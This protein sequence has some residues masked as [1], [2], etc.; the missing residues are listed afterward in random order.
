MKKFIT[1]L[2]A[3]CITLPVWAAD[4]AAGIANPATPAVK[5]QLDQT[6]KAN[7]VSGPT[8][9]AGA[10]L[11]DIDATILALKEQ[12][13]PVP[14]D[15]YKA[16]RELRGLPVHEV[17]AG[18][19]GGDTVGEATN[20]SSLPFSDTGTTIGYT[21]DYDEVCPYTDSTSPDVVYSFTPGADITVYITLCNG[22]DY[23]TKL[24]VYENEVTPGAPFACNDD[25]CVNYESELYG[26]EL[27]YGNTYFIVIDGYFGD[28]GNY[29]LDI[30][31][32]G[33]CDVECPPE[34][35]DEGEEE[36]YDEYV[37]AT[38]GG[39]NSDPN[40]FGAVGI[41][42]YVCGKGGTFMFEGGNFRD[43][44]WFEF[45][46]DEMSTVYAEV[47]AEFPVALFFVDAT[48]CNAPAVIISATTAIQCDPIFIETILD[49]GVYV[50]FVAPSVFEGWGCDLEYVA[51]L[52]AE[53]FETEEGDACSAPLYIDAFPYT[54]VGTTAD[55][56]D[57]Y[58]NASPDEW[59]EFTIEGSQ[60]MVTM[61]LCGPETDYDTYLYL[62]SGDCVTEIA[63]NDDLC[64]LQSELIMSLSP[65]DYVVG[66]DGFSTSSGDYQLGISLGDPYVYLP[67]QEVHTPEESWSAG[68]SHTNGDDVDY[69]RAERFGQAGNITS[70]QLSGLSLIYDSGWS[71]C[72]EDPM[73]FDIWFYEDGGMPGEMLANFY[74]EASP[75]ATG[76]DFNEFPLYTF[77]LPIPDRYYIEE[78]WV[79]VQTSN[80]CWFLWMSA[81][82]VDGMSA[83]S[84]LGGPWETYAYDMAYCM[85]L[86][87]DVASTTTPQTVTLEQNHPNPFNPVTTI[88]YG[89]T[90]PA[91][92]E[93][94]VYNIAGETVSTLVDGPQTAGMHSLQFDGSNLPSG[95]Y[96]YRLSTEDFSRTQRMLLV[97]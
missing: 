4:S 60:H 93:L 5:P 76:L 53:P 20:I 12:N 57:T 81:Y 42:E 22:S 77:D 67:C 87:D 49:A 68:T 66:V 84:T 74:V 32:L 71:T 3:L 48:D 94:V 29:V 43:T 65:G 59:H 41:G 44:D 28:E 13:L 82:G 95:I 97:K 51:Y 56:V 2:F 19:Q 35:N 36:C 75:V 52:D 11:A 23:D 86:G 96:F 9:A 15:L 45:T 30:T 89:L 62:L 6:A 17:P 88:S 79:A 63:Y 8:T 80:V 85:T 46:I 90:S 7:P 72:A 27:F 24:Y 14:A 18:R 33:D 54:F 58:G 38:N 64:D 10:E 39:C 92:V 73:G 40:V 55:N 26:L 34:G 61:E 31:Q 69:L 16:A 50:L 78:G 21:D 1:L 25:A 83:L 70:L 47:E 37:D 91:E